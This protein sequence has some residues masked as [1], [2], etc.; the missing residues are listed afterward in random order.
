MLAR[1][2]VLAGSAAG[3][4]LPSVRRHRGRQVA[5][6]SRPVAWSAISSGTGWGVALAG[7]AAILLGDQ[8]RA[9]WLLFAA[10]A[11]LVGIVA[12][13]A[14]PRACAPSAQG[15]RLEWSWFVCPR[16]GPLLASA[17]LV[18]VGSS[19]WWAFSVDAMRAAGVGQDAARLVYAVCGVAGVLASVTGVATSRFGVRGVHVLAGVLVTGA[20]A[21]LAFGSASVGLVALAAV[22]FG[23][24]YNGVIAT[25]GLW[26]ADVF[27]E[28]PS[29]G[30]AAVNTALTAGTITG[31][32]TA[33]VVI[34]AAGYR[35]ALLVAAA[36]LAVGVLL[37][38]P[39]SRSTGGSTLAVDH[40]RS[41]A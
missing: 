39:R 20:L 36:V 35:P 8:W 11:V 14:A 19:V 4:G 18:G 6:R 40:D 23:V 1:G 5:P 27:A 15:P 41:H 25:Q 37:K 32:V 22:L 30:L 21:C 31:P 28:R 34:D 7:P 3:L 38:P 9:V 2:V 26:S 16:S 12:V 33:G 17:V 13:R 29:A 24:S 10:L